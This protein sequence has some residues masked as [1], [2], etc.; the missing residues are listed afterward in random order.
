MSPLSAWRYG[1]A[2]PS[3]FAVLSEI[4]PQPQAAAPP[5]QET[6]PAAAAAAQDPASHPSSEP[7]K[8]ESLLDTLRQRQKQQAWSD[9]L[10]DKDR[11]FPKAEVL[12]KAAQP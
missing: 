6:Q 8:Q 3:V 4:S 7:A 5:P 9:G 2:D 12:R 1:S 11:L 10:I